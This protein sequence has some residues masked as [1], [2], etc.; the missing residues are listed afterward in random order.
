MDTAASL[1]HKK[2]ADDYKAELDKKQKEFRDY[3]AKQQEALAARKSTLI[4]T[5]TKSDASGASGPN[6]ETWTRDALSLAD[7]TK[8]V[9]AQFRDEQRIL[10]DLTIYSQS[11]DV[12]SAQVAKNNALNVQIATAE[13]QK[14]K[15]AFEQAQNDKVATAEKTTKAI[16][17]IDETGSQESMTATFAAIKAENDA[18]LQAAK[19]QFKTWD[20]GYKPYAA[21]PER[22]APSRCPWSGRRKDHSAACR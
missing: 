13:A 17:A 5:L 12:A 19:E 4:D 16:V 22:S 18:T 15:A 11:S 8:Q 20:E 10:N 14:S 21:H 7:A 6:G 3:L 2:E 1:G 9:N